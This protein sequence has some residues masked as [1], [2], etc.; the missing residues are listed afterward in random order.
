M[1]CDILKIACTIT[2]A[3]SQYNHYRG[4]HPTITAKWCVCVC[5]CVCDVNKNFASPFSI[6]EL[7]QLP[8]QGLKR[9]TRGGVLAPAVKHDV[10]ILL[11][12]I[13][14]ARHAVPLLYLPNDLSASKAS[15]VREATVG[16]DLVKDD[17]KRPH[18]RLD[19]VTIVH[20][21]L[22]C[23]PFHGKIVHFFVEEHPQS[24]VCHLACTV[25]PNKDV[26]CGQKTVDVVLLFEV[27][28]PRCHLGPNVN[29]SLDIQGASLL[30]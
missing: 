1:Y 7:F 10:M 26:S 29:Q 3:D 24:Q 23:S 19:D 4:T 14:R 22:R 15:R 17:S 28:H 16:D 30:P 21:S 18:V 13:A 11:G 27:A 6:K 12:A 20:G 8:L 25:F 5:V 9:G 2:M